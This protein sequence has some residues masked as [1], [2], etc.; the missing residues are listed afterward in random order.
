MLLEGKKIVVIGGCSGT[1][2]ATAKL[3]A[4]EGASVVVISRRSPQ[5]T[6]AA[7]IVEECRAAGRGVYKFISADAGVE[8]QIFPAIQEAADFMGGIDGM[9]CAAHSA[10]IVPTDIINREEFMADVNTNIFGTLFPCQ[11][12][13]P[14][15]KESSSP[16]ILT[17]CANAV[18][19]YPYW[20]AAY[21]GTKMA[22]IGMTRTMAREW[23][24]FNIRVNCMEMVT[25]TESTFDHPA[26]WNKTYQE[27]ASKAVGDI[28]LHSNRPAF[29]RIPEPMVAAHTV[30]FL[31]SDRASFTTGQTI[32]VD[33]GASC[34]HV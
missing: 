16:S 27:R 5:Q 32:H 8:S 33:G 14:Y 7:S 25:S 17:C 2:R 4:E 30:V 21:T 31:L 24:E 28:L 12:A 19:S 26:M 11:A 1:G 3:A 9:L 13:L 6:M 10:T 20:L 18:S 34:S 29:D 22:V 23:G 15:L